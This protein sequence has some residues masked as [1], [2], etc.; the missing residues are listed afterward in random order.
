MSPDLLKIMCKKINSNE[1]PIDK[2]I[3]DVTTIKKISRGY[4]NNSFKNSVGFFSDIFGM[5]KNIIFLF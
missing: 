1:P 5:C 4:A 2:Y 3:I